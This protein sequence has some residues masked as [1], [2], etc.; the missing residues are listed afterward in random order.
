MPSGRRL[1]KLYKTLASES[2][3]SL[4]ACLLAAP[5]AAAWVA[6]NYHL[7]TNSLAVAPLHI[8]VVM[9]MPQQLQ[10]DANDVV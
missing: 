7:A 6:R 2:A 1:A 5:S 10:Q 3:V 4:N 8:V 9:L